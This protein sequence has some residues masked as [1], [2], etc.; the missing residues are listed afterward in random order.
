MTCRIGI[1]T[2]LNARKDDWKRKYPKSF[3]KWKQLGTHYSKSAAQARETVLAKQHGCESH[4][5][6]GGPEKATWHV[7]YFEHDGT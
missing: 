5:G 2:D 4:A 6:G 7:Y 1:T 3:R